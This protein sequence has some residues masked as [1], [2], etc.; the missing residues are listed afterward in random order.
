MKKPFF[1]IILL[2]L[3]CACGSDGENEAAPAVSGAAVTFSD[4]LGRQVTVDRP[5]RVACLTASFADIWCQAGGAAQITAATNATWT[6]FDL[7][8]NEDVVNLGQSKHLDLE[9]LIACQPDLIL[10]SCGT[11]RNRELETLLG[12]LGVPVA[13]FSV[14]SFDDYL[15]VLDICTRITGCPENY[16]QNGTA[17]QAQVDTALARADGSQ[18]KVL[19]IRVTGN[20][21]KV[22]S[23]KDTVLGELLA[24]LDCVNIADREGALLEQL[25]MEVILREDP[26]HIFIVLQ[27]ADPGAARQVLETTLLADPAWNSLTAVKED[28]CHLMDPNLFNLKPNAR[29]GEAY[30]QLAEILY[31]AQ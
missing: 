1:L 17:V 8:L 14:N 30:E 20:G 24:A 21:C 2:C 18:P 28:R 16:E 12:Q 26:E 9:Q 3:L 27:S 15:R 23:S 4:D 7:P 19:Y 13:Y 29:W 10:A 22:K 31:P 6:Y 11:D 25:S 5:Q